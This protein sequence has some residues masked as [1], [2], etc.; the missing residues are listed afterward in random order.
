MTYLFFYFFSFFSL[1]IPSSDLIYS[2]IVFTSFS[3]LLLLYLNILHALCL[4]CS[5]YLF[6]NPVAMF[7]RIFSQASVSVK[8]ALLTSSRMSISIMSKPLIVANSVSKFQ[9]LP[10]CMML[11]KPTIFSNSVQ[12]FHIKKKTNRRKT[13][14]PYKLKTHRYISETKPPFY[15]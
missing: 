2:S 10:A 8:S 15:L 7:K 14:K 5:I 3:S 4:F 6:P 11:N 1:S 13:T 12:A 9:T